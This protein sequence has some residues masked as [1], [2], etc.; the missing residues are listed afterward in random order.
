MV[1]SYMENTYS[2]TLRTYV[3]FLPNRRIS[4]MISNNFDLFWIEFVISETIHIEIS[5][6]VP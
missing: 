3:K 2:V 6:G 1:D 4:R 5:G